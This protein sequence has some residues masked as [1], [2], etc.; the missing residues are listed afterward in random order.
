MGGLS[1]LPDLIPCRAASSVIARDAKSIEVRFLWTANDQA[2]PEIMLVEA[3]AQFAGGLVFDAQGG[4]WFTDHGRNDARVHRL[5]GVFYAHPDGSSI[6][7]VLFP[8]GS[9]N[10]IGLSPAGT[11][12]YR[13]EEHPGPGT[14]R[15]LTAPAAREIRGA[16][17]VLMTSRREC[18][19]PEEF[20]RM[21]GH[22]RFGE[23][24]LLQMADMR[25]HD[26]THLDQVTA[27]IASAKG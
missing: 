7:E 6:R 4:I 14:G 16:E 1:S 3:M 27:A 23:R 24:P 17:R 25:N 21:G 5:G 8:V 19:R 22:P 26:R 11:P 10:G 18:L 9:P 2:T 15:G 13:A 12:R 20:A